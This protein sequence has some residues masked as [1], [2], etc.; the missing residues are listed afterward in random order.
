MKLAIRLAS[1]TVVLVL[2]AVILI[3]TQSRNGAAQTAEPFV[4]G[5]FHGVLTYHNDNQRTGRNLYETILTPSNVRV[6]SFGKLF[7]ISTDG[8]VDAQPLYV[9]NLSINGGTHNT[10]LY[11]AGA[12][13]VPRLS[14]FYARLI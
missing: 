2:V 11:D 8:R 5:T 14:E 1:L 6:G 12:E 3:L 9:P 13:Y 7:T 4:A 10:L